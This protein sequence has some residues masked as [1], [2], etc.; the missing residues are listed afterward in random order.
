MGFFMAVKTT[1]AQLEEVQ[2]AIT[3]VMSGQAVTIDGNQHTLASLDALNKREEMLL[4][5]Y[6]SETGRG[7]CQNIAIPR[8]D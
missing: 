8:R 1:L 2:T 5:R 3:A 4:S 7:M 6:K